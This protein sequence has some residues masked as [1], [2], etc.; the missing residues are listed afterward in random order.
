[1]IPN[2]IEAEAASKARL[3]DENSTEVVT[4]IGR[5]AKDVDNDEIEASFPV[6]QGDAKF[7]GSQ[8]FAA[9]PLR[10]QHGRGKSNQPVWPSHR[11]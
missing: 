1:M 10:T 11:G 3:E 8:R 7:G 2:L 5:F 4:S 6:S 9:G